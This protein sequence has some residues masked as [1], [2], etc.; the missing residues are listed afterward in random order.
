M[1]WLTTGRF[2]YAGLGFIFSIALVTVVFGQTAR[3]D[4]LVSAKLVVGFDMGVKTSENK[5]D[6]PVPCCGQQWANGGLDI[7]T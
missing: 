1:I 7:G 3:K 6:V 5:L 4:I 2:G